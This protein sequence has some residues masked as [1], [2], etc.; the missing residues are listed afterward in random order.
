MQSDKRK[1]TEEEK[2]S[3]PSSKMDVISKTVTS[4]SHPPLFTDPKVANPV[5]SMNYLIKYLPVPQ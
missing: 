2:K 1:S 5:I 3:Q 4:I